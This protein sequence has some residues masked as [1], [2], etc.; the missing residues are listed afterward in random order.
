MSE[1]ATKRKMERV[2]LAQ[3]RT[4]AARDAAAVA[5]R[6]KHVRASGVRCGSP[7]LRE[8]PFCYYHNHLYNQPYEPEF[9]FLE[10]APAISGAIQ[11]VLEELRRDALDARKAGVMLYGLQTAMALLGRRG[12]VEP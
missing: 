8:Q 7:A 3:E 10:D 1:K 11:R 9:P 4:A 6:C 5:L 2:T 12:A